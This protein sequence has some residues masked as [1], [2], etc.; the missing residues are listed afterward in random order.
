MARNRKNQPAA[1]RFGPAIKA[2]FLCLFIGGSGVGYVWQKDQLLELGRHRAEREKRLNRLRVENSLL[3]QH[4]VE[5]ESPRGL[6]AKLKELKLGL[7]V[8]QPTQIVR[9]RDLPI[10]ADS[11]PAPEPGQPDRKYA[12]QQLA[13]SAEP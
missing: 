13:V 2:L 5:L 7:I 6:E 9:L 12:R 1:L 4:L 8:A 3:V 10:P 11:A